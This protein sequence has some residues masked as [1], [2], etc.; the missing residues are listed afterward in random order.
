MS[1]RYEIV[2]TG[3]LALDLTKEVKPYLKDPPDE[4]NGLIQLMISAV[5]QYAE[6]YMGVDL[7]ARTWK[8]FLDSFETRICLKKSRVASVTT[9]QYTLAT[10][11]TTIISTTYYLKIGTQFSEILLKDDKSWPTDGDDKVKEATIEIVFVT[12]IPEKI[13]GYKLAMLKHIAYL[14]QNRGDI[15]TE[16]AAKKSG[17]AFFYN[18]NRIVRV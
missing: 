18:Q 5:Q 12:K 2:T 6:G 9:V 15:T 14:Y 7:R 13:D 1:T 10:V 16:D 3:D 4:D 8:L 17:A 11:L